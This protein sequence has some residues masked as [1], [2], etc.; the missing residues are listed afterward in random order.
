MPK[1]QPSPWEYFARTVNFLLSCEVL[2]WSMGKIL[3]SCRNQIKIVVCF[4][5]VEPQ[6]TETTQLI[7]IRLRMLL[8]AK[9]STLTVVCFLSVEPQLTE[10]T[11]LLI[12]L[13]MLLHA[14]VLTLT[15]GILC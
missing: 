9:V 13:R 3:Q 15:M 12:R 10:T 6:L 1:Y 5:S 14:K 11:Q 2:S 4:L 7:L 8:H